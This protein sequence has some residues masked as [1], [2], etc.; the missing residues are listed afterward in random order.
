VNPD[1]QFLL[2]FVGIGTGDLFGA[3]M[4]FGGGLLALIMFGQIGARA[5]SVV[6]TDILGLLLGLTCL[7]CGVRFL[8]GSV[9]ILPVCLA[10]W[11]VQVPHLS[12]ASIEYRF[13]SGA[14]V[15]LTLSVARVNVSL[16]WKLGAG[17][18]VG[19]DST[20]ADPYLGANLFAVAGAVYFWFAWKR[21]R[22]VSGRSTD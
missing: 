4:I 22:G 13:F 1:Q 21:A 6:A 16:D 8:R 17:L 3:M 9:A 7:W 15:D 2:R 5:G 12:L 11:A 18:R 10:I 20:A 14:A 19:A